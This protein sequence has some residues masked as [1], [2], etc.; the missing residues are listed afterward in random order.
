MKNEKQMH[1]KRVAFAIINDTVHFIYN[2]E[3]SHYTWLVID[4]DMKEQD[5]NELTRGMFLDNNLY[6]YGEDFGVNDNVRE[7]AKKHVTTI[8]T[9]IEKT[10]KVD[11]FSSK[12]YLGMIKGEVGRLW[13]PI[14]ELKW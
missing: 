3:R 7:Q 1:R 8:Y 14:E 10:C 13:E 12:V 2:D 11:Y 6:L 5:F 4:N 9:Q